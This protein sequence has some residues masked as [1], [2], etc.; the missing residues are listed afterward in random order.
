MLSPASTWGD[1]VYPANLGKLFVKKC[2]GTTMTT[3]SRG[4]PEYTPKPDFASWL[5]AKGFPAEYHDVFSW[6]RER[7][8]AEYDQLFTRAEEIG[9]QIKQ[10]KEQ[11]EALHN[12]RKEYMK[13][14]EI[15]MWSK[16]D[17]IKDAKHLE[18]KEHFFSEIAT[19]NE[20]GRT[21]QRTRDADCSAIPFLAGIL[22]GI[23]RDY[24][25]IC[26]DERHTHNMASSNSYDPIWKTIGPMRNM[27]WSMYPKIDA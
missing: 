2:R 4:G 14:H 18:M 6:P 12:Q 22:E 13:D 17:Q 23:Y 9:E 26:N 19:V 5:D 8:Y 27:F 1:V 25:K 10:S 15:D 24:T 11:F 3:Y 16:L 20:A 7:V 21:L